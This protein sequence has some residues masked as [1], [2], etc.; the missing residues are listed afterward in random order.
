MSVSPPVP[1]MLMILATLSVSCLMLFVPSL[2]TWQ[3]FLPQGCRSWCIGGCCSV[4]GSVCFY[5]MV[6]CVGPRFVAPPGVAIFSLWATLVGGDCCVP[7]LSDWFA[8]WPT[9]SVFLK[10]CWILLFACVWC[11]GVSFSFLEILQLCL[12]ANQV[13]WF[14]D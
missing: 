5:L 11:P 8:A 3:P 6:T 2:C 9:V 10:I 1:A 14:L 12:R 13:P 7:S 4:G